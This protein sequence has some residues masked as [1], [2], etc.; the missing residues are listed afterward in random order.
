MYNF[1]LLLLWKWA[2]AHFFFR[3]IT[4]S[5]GNDRQSLKIRITEL[6]EKTAES[7]NMEVVLTEIKSEGGRAI[8]RV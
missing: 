5:D 1:N 3:R 2:F 6:A 8:V 7:M 4:V